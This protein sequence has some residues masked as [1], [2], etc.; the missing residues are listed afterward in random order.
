MHF[1]QTFRQNP[2]VPVIVID[3][4][5]HAIPLAKTLLDAGFSTIEITLRTP[6]ALE[7][8]HAIRTTLPTMTVGAGTIL[9]TEQLSLAKAAGAQF[10]VSPGLLTS[11]VKQA[12]KESLPYFPGVMTLSEIL[13]AYTQ[14][15]RH[16][17]FFPAALAGGIP[18]LKSVAAVFP[19]VLFFPTGGIHLENCTEYLKLASVL[20]IGGTWITP[21]TLLVQEDFQAIR[22][23]AEQAQQLAR[24]VR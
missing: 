14:G 2:I 21:R 9:T 13:F 15:L 6:C 7:A 8:I 5:K 20:C 18:F 10:V 22:R 16:L 24:T 17:K 23:L 11:L 12:Q 4:S 1:V 19:E 3:Q